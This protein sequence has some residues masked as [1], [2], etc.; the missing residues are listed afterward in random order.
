MQY[1]SEFYGNA[2]NVATNN[3]VVQTKKVT[4]NYPFVDF[5]LNARIRPVRF[6]IKLDHLNQGLTGNNYQLTPGYYQ[7]DRAFKF[8]I[9][10]L[11]YD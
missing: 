4:G 1:Y 11:F 8:G 7:N 10:W 2:Y 5:F 3:Y 6:F 9:N